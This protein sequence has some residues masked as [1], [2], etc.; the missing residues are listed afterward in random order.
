[1]KN[2][3]LEV[4]GFWGVFRGWEGFDGWNYFGIRGEST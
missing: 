3:R 2:L 4:N 1:M